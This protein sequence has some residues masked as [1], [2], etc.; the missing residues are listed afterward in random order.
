[1]ATLP[2]AGT[3]SGFRHPVPVIEIRAARLQDDSVLV[4]V[5]AATW[6][7]GVSPAPPPSAETA[8]FSGRAKPEDVLVAIVD[9]DVVGYA[10]LGQ[11]TALASHEHVLDWGPMP[12][13]AVCTRRTA[14]WSKAFCAPSSSW[15]ARTSTT[16]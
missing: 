12:L 16:F 3:C 5:D 13:P 8:F 15:T 7:T 10:R 2:P 4:R 14:S 1:M 11:R 6:T 9:D